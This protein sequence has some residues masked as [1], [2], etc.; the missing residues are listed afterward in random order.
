MRKREE[1]GVVENKLKSLFV[2]C[3]NTNVLQELSEAESAS[4]PDEK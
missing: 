4:E 2:N 3:T 1:G